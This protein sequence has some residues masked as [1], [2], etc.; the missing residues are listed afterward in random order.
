[1]SKTARR[2]GALLALACVVGI[3]APASGGE[4]SG[5][6]VITGVDKRS[7][8]T[9][10]AATGADIEGVQRDR[11]V[12][13]ATDE[14][15]R[16]L[17]EQGFKLQRISERDDPVTAYDF[18]QQHAGYHNYAEMI[19]DI[20]AVANVHSATV[21]LFSIG[22]SYQ[23]RDLVAARI[24]D[25]ASDNPAEPGVLYVA[26]HHAREHLTV[27]VALDL[28]HTFAESTDPTVQS[29]VLSRQIYIVFNLNPDG[30][31]YDISG[32]R[33]MY[34][35]KN[36]QPTPDSR[37]IGTD[38]NRNYSYRWGCCRGSSPRPASQTYRGPAPFSAPET[39]A[40]RD[41]V[42]AHAN[43]RTSISYHSYGR[44]ILYP[45]GYTYADV[46]PDMTQVDHNA[47]VEI[48]AE[49]ARTTGY[50]P[51][52]GS[53]L[54]ITDGTFDD[55]MYGERHIYPFTFELGGSGFYPDDSFIP[56]ETA[57]NRA[58]AIYVAQVADCPTF[59]VDVAC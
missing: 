18:P 23:G 43:V 17:R 39:A 35:R 27:E 49:M 22:L 55:W 8:R 24:S 53:D 48:A 47:L 32:D 1:V 42:L 7:Q 12:V 25:D 45:Y 26:S 59:V 37:R 21:H 29:L 11:V 38:L 16:A 58:A 30:S 13:G 31:E 33:Y 41:F 14:E 46:P 36:R 52:Q 19:A 51:E 20:Q 3:V 15:Y 44:L 50:R 10:I 56:I 28:L 54:Y 57:R 2:F 5:R 40:L 4:S 34:W 6:Y 9:S